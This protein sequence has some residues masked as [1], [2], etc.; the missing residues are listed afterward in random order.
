MQFKIINMHLLRWTVAAV[1]MVFA[2]DIMA[3]KALAEGVCP[4][5]QL[6]SE[7]KYPSGP[8]KCEGIASYNKLPLDDREPMRFEVHQMSVAII[9]LQ[10]TGTIT[11]DTPD[12][13]ERF[14]ATSDAKMS[15]WLYLHSPGGDLMAGLKLGEAIR[16]HRL[17][18]G[19][20]RSVMLEKGTMSVHSYRQAVCASSCAYA[21]LGGVSRSY[22][23]HDIYGLHRFG[24]TDRS[25][26]GD[27]AQM[28]TSLLANYVDRMGV[29]QAVLTAASSAAFKNDIFP[30]DVS[31]AKQM[32]VIFDPSGRTNFVVEQ[33]GGHAVASFKFS[34]QEKQFQGMI[35]CFKGRKLMFIYDHF[36]AIP[37]LLEQTKDFRASFL[38]NAEKITG[39]ATF[40][41]SK[42]RGKPNIFLFDIPNLKPSSF[43]GDGI[44]LEQIWNPSFPVGNGKEV[45]TKNKVAMAKLSQNFL[46]LDAVNAFPLKLIADNGERTLPLVFKDCGD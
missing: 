15:N 14:M 1:Y 10:G 4:T 35:A 31:L 27:E 39:S 26:S 23:E 6:M 21:F 40:I 5:G 22:S 44:S 24:A 42:V 9:F 36:N 46:W 13:F 8:Q 45:D 28:V 7:D 33:R 16:K 43:R 18:T 37:S 17:N 19:I 34:I 29:D 3:Q 38:S 25:I 2:N 12:E 30:V 11:Q 20:S 41:S 32:R